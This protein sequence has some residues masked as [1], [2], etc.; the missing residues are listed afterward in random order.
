M[1]MAA[2]RDGQYEAINGDPRHGRFMGW[3]RKLYAIGGGEI[4]KDRLTMTCG[5]ALML[6]IQILVGAALFIISTEKAYAFVGRAPF[7]PNHNTSNIAADIEW[8]KLAGHPYSAA[9]IEAME[10]DGFSW[11]YFRL[12]WFL[13]SLVLSVLHRCLLFDNARH[14]PGAIGTRERQSLSGVQLKPGVL[15]TTTA[16]SVQSPVAAVAEIWTADVRNDQE[17]FAAE[18][19]AWLWL[20]VVAAWM[21]L[22]VIALL[23]DGR[24]SFLWVLSVFATNLFP[25]INSAASALLLDEKCVAVHK[26][27]ERMLTPYGIETVPLT[28]TGRSKWVE[29]MTDCAGGTTITADALSAPL[30][31]DGAEQLLQAFRD[32]VDELETLSSRWSYAMGVQGCLLLAQLANTTATLW[33]RHGYQVSL[34][35]DTELSDN[36][37]FIYLVQTFPVFWALWLSFNTMIHLNTYLAEI[38][39]RVS[40]SCDAQKLSFTDRNAFAQ[41]YKRLGVHLDVPYVGELT[42]KTRYGALVS[43]AGLLLTAVA[44]PAQLKDTFG[45]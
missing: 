45:L 42:T 23:S 5:N 35:T 6:C 31:A 10:E 43:L 25:I 11:T 15:S 33:Q 3:Q 7:A 12:T 1:I 39:S 21:L 14:D 26:L 41:E 37:A 16:S 18:H 22:P 38:P 9:E 19:F 4:R 13:L 40:R 44:V 32:L 30:S 36:F 24:V 27:V 29:R 8:A 20:P 17:Y 28:G 2:Q 34:L